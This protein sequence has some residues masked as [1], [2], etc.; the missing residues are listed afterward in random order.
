[1][2]EPAELTC[3]TPRLRRAM[4]RLL[5]HEAPNGGHSE[6]LAAASGRLLDRLLQRLSVVIG[7]AGVEALL[8]RAVKLRKADFPFLDVPRA[9]GESAGENLRDRLREHD[10]GLIK[11][12]SITLFATFAGL[13]ITVIGEKIAWSLLQE[14]WPEAL[15]PELQESDE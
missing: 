1:M 2:G 15:R 10:A 6:D 11:E 13:L 4:T 5:D 7:T 14:V 8:S 9:H 3:A 12:V